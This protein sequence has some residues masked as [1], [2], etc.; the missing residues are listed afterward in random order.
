MFDTL[1]P[2]PVNPIKL[3]GDTVARPAC[4]TG[5]FTYHETAW[6]GNCDEDD[7]IFDACVEGWLPWFPPTL[8]PTIVPANL[9]FGR[10]GEVGYLGLLATPIG[11]LLCRPQ[12]QTKTRRFVY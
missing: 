8:T 1:T 9:T 4:G 6:T 5:A 2:F 10:V 3:I 12:P 7:Q 11:Q